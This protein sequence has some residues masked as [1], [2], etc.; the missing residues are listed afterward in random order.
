M[1]RKKRKLD[2]PTAHCPL[3]G[4]GGSIPPPPPPPPTGGEKTSFEVKKYRYDASA[5]RSISD[6]I[7]YVKNQRM[8]TD[9]AFQIAGPHGAVAHKTEV[10]ACTLSN[11]PIGYGRGKSRDH[12]INNACISSMQIL[13]SPGWQDIVLNDDCCTQQGGFSAPVMNAFAPPPPMGMPPPMMGGIPPPFA[14]IGG[15]PPPM[16]GGFPPP[17]MG[18]IPPPNGVPP[19]GLPPAAVP[20]PAQ[21]VQS[22]APPLAVVQP[23][24]SNPPVAPPAAAVV[25][26]T[27]TVFGG[28]TKKSVKL[29][30]NAG[31]PNSNLVFFDEDECMEEKRATLSRYRVQ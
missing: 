17:I 6:F 11:E 19:P 23:P 31:K 18:G 28:A 3:P 14:M 8:A 20:P 25:K 16:M 9:A 4:L 15:V 27:T 29:T 7:N 26:P 21:P 5:F 10:W 22:G 12:A 1:G 24:S 30:M 13:R 2:A